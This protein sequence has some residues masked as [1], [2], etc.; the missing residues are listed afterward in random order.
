MLVSVLQISVAAG[1]DDFFKQAAALF[2]KNTVL[3]AWRDVEGKPK[4][5]V[6]DKDI[7]RQNLIDCMVRSIPRVRYGSQRCMIA[8][9]CCLLCSVQLAVMVKSIAEE[10]YPERWPQVLDQ[11]MGYMGSA[12]ISA[13]YSALLA[14]RGI[15]RKFEYDS[16]SP[17]VS[18]C[19]VVACV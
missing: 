5:P 6:Q 17:S 19:A 11:V 4:I 3:L 10:D 8:V 12:D 13:V 18:L 1:I 14:L 9:L 7:V 2:A 16:L 15:F